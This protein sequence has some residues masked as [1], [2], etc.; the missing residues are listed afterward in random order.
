MPGKYPRPAG[1]FIL[2]NNGKKGKDLR[3]EDVTS[4]VAPDLLNAGLVTD[5]AWMDFD[6]DG[7]PDL[8]LAGEWMSIRFFENVSGKFSDVTEEKG[9]SN[10][11]GWWYSLDAV[12]VDRD[13]DFDLIAGNLGKNFK[14]RDDESFA[15]FSNDFDVNGKQDIIFSYVQNNTRYPIGSFDASSRQIPVIGQ[16]YKTF[17]EFARA[18]LDDI[19]GPSILKTSYSRAINTFASIWIENTGQGKFV[20]HTLPNWAQLSSINAMAE[21]DKQGNPVFVVGGN[22]YHTEVETPRNDASIGLVLTYDKQKGLRA[23]PPNESGLMIRGEIREIIPIQL[24]T[25]KTAILFA[26]NDGALKLLEVDTNY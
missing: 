23:M 22:L 24:A 9:F 16:R 12:D 7:D 11:I 14:Y 18:S 3:F 13:G 4:F 21:I 6:S 25:G 17:D 8:I 19:Y 2:R 20:S 1:S 26:L 15:V 10:Y 5:A